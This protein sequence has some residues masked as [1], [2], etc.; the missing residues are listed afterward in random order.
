MLNQLTG[1]WKRRRW[2]ALVAFA[3]PAAVVLGLITS[4]PNL[5]R[6]TA[7]VLV[8]RQQ[9][10]EAFVQPTVTGEL[11]TRLQTM[12][13]EILS[14]A[15]LA[16]LVTRFNLYPGLRGYLSIDEL[17]DRMRS[18]IAVVMK[19][20]GRPQ[21]AGKTVAFTVGFRGADPATVAEVTN[22]LASFYVEQN[23]KV[24]A[25]QSTATADFL[26]TQ[27]DE[28]KKQLDGLERQV[29][30]YTRRHIGELPQQMPTNLAA[31]EQLGSQLRINSDRQTLALARRE[32]LERQLAD[33]ELAAQRL[34]PTPILM[35]SGAPPPDAT[36]VRLERLRQE[37]TELRSQ[38]TERY[39]EVTRVKAE[40]AAVE[41]ELR[42]K[43]VAPASLEVPVAPAPAP[44]QDPTVQRIKGVLGEINAELKALKDDERRLQTAIERYHA[45]V[46]STPRREQEFQQLSRDYQTTKEHY[47]TLLK[48]YQEAQLAE[49]MEQRQKGEQ[50]AVLD[51][52]MVPKRPAAPDRLRFLLMGLVVSVA[53]T[54]AVVWLAEQVDTSFHGLNEVRGYTAVP[55]LVNIPTILAPADLAARRRRFWLG[56]VLLLL[57]LSA[58]GGVAHR[59]GDGNEW[60]VGLLSRS[61]TT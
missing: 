44:A 19:S 8:E 43:P 33:A 1:V 22:T 25:R 3:V 41:R 15:R 23:I 54:V 20:D 36:T 2:I 21:S 7:T 12:S 32:A 61:S 35:S 39:P 56:I 13:Q 18:D 31:I 6:S 40:I 4:L 52:A 24:R 17:V 38:Y 16:D 11:E 57:T 48:R 30:D 9:V 50:F 14:R 53:A 59:V 26:R 45:R 10:P 51:S 28:T 60:L 46:E 55:V 58:L 37:L 42:G 29:S 49:D 47:Q 27:L 5:Y 34:G